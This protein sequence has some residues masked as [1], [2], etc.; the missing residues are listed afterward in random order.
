ML[1][2]LDTSTLE[3]ALENYLSRLCLN[4]R[5]III[6]LLNKRSLNFNRTDR[7]KA[8]ESN[9]IRSDQKSR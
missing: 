5:S 9:Q 4:S 1:L 8:N 3:C 7:L 6:I 2:L